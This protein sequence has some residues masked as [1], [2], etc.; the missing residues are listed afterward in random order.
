MDIEM[1]PLDSIRP[2]PG[3]PRI[4]DAAVDAVVASIKEFGFRQPIVVDAEGVIVVGH[5]RFKA[6][7]KM[8]LTEVPVHVATDLTPAQARAYR[9]ADNQ[10]AAIAEWDKLLLPVELTGLQADGFDLDVLGFDEEELSR[11][12]SAGDDATGLTDPDDVPALP[13]N[14]VT[15]PG[16]LWL[17]GEHRL[18]CGDSTNAGDVARLLDG[19]VPFLMTT[20]PPYGVEYHASWRHAAG[21]NNS[22]RVGE[23]ANDHRFDWTDAYK[24]FPGAVAYIWHAGV[25][26][27]PVASHLET[28]GFEIRAQIIWRKPRFV[29]SRGHYHWSH[30]PCWYCV[31]PGRTGGSKWC[32]DRSQST[33]WDVPQRDDTGDTQHSTQKP[34]ECMSRP[35]RHHG[36]K[37][38]HVY[39]PFLG[40]GTTLIAA[41]QRGRRC[42]AMELDPRYVDVAVQRWEKFTGKKAE[43]VSEDTPASA[44]VSSS[45]GVK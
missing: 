40:S 22:D 2:Y 21:L 28:A 20:D 17:L 38:D 11:W 14:P 4:N 6:A 10:T 44:G 32:G 35:I 41:E 33:V 19:T 5:T 16:D 39:D 36:G 30:E 29:I 7:K 13:E 45:E 25:Y 43:R 31:R 9:I 24:L 1:R 8:G 23:V 15:Q 37:D 34:V 18:L 27:G 12:L 26:S 42:F 3:N